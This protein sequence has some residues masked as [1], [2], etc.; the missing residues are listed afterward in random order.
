MAN[1]WE[2]PEIFKTQRSVARVPCL[3]GSK[4]LY[5][6]PG[7]LW[8]AEMEHMVKPWPQLVLK[9]SEAA[10]QILPQ[11]TETDFPRPSQR[12][13]GP[14]C[15]PDKPGRHWLS[16]PNSGLCKGLDAY[17]PCCQ[18]EGGD[19]TL[20]DGQGEYNSGG[21]YLGSNTCLRTNETVE[22]HP[23]RGSVAG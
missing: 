16:Y 7:E 19:K 21:Q 18:Q 8:E 15:L 5:S 23:V 17:S 4:S 2:G 6:A 11:S 1:A 14:I 12:A 10:C 3:G 13:T 9:L 22:S 20:M